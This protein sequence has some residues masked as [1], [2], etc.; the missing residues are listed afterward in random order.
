MSWLGDPAKLWKRYSNWEGGTADPMIVSWPARITSAGVRRQ[1]VHAIDIV[2]ALY[3]V[4]GIEPPEVVKG[5]PQFPLEGVS[6]EA[7]LN[8]ATATT[9]KQT[10]SGSGCKSPGCSARRGGHADAFSPGRH[11]ARG[12]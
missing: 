5:Y 7:T 8:D 10:R 9:G 2:P 12:G 4:L 3:S 11:L 1:Y 6:F